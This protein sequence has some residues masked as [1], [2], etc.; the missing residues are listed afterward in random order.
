MRGANSLASRWA[1]R[2]NDGWL[3]LQRHDHHLIAVGESYDFRFVDDDCLAGFD[4]QDSCAGFLHGPQGAEADG[5]DV[6]A[7]VLLGLGDF[8]DGEITGR[9]ELAGAADARVGAFDGFQGQHGEMLHRHALADVEQR[10][11]GQVW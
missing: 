2:L 8:H 5:G 7:H 6:E 4:G 10:A 11:I 9:A 1:L 3:V